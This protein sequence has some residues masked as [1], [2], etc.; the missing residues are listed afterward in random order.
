M[1]RRLACL[2]LTVTVA[3]ASS[4]CGFVRSAE[5]D[6]FGFHYDQLT[7]L[8]ADMQE[9]RSRGETVAQ[10]V[11]R[12]GDAFV[13]RD[14]DS[15]DVALGELHAR[16]ASSIVR[17][18]P[19]VSLTASWITLL[20]AGYGSPHDS[21]FVQVIYLG[22]GTPLCIPF[23][24]LILPLSFAS[25]WVGDLGVSAADHQRAIEDLEHARRLGCVNP[26]RWMR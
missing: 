13:D 20:T 1:H 23:D 6:A 2:V 4:A 9:S 11:A 7:A 24:V 14:L 8:I 26:D 22:V 16:R 25:S 3:L 10:W 15:W 19:V 5:K 17:E 21:R 18:A 12:N